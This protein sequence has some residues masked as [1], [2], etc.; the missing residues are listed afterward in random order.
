MDPDV[1]A[2]RPWPP[3]SYWAKVTIVVALTLYVLGLAQ[4]VLNIV[5]LVVIAAVLAIGLDPAVRRL[6]RLG[7]RR[8][9]AVVAIFAGFVLF[10]V[11]F[12]WVV[13]PPLVHQVTQL[14]NDI[15]TYAQRL[16]ARG[17]WV[18]RYF[19]DHD[20]A[21]TVKDFVANLP[22]RI[23]SSFGTILGVAG[24]VGSALFNVVTVAILMIYFM[25]ALPSMRKGSAV[26]FSPERRDRAE[27]VMDQS[28]A[29]IGGYVAGNLVTSLICG[30]L[31]LLAFSVLGVPFA[32]PL[33]M[34]AG[35][36]DL[37]PAV[38]SYLGAAPAVAVGFFQSPLTGVLVLSY[39]LVYQQFENYFLVPK[40]M[41]N[42]V[43]LSPAAVIISTLVG[44]SL[45]G[46]AGALLALP[47]AATIKV[48]LYDVWLRGRS[49]GDSLVQEHLQAELAAE[50]EAEAGAAARAANRRRMVARLRGAFRP[51]EGP[52][53]PE[54]PGPSEEPAEEP[55]EG[56]SE[57]EDR[58]TRD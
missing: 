54:G 13:V 41:Q 53:P 7:M 33:A 19:R 38:G 18:G 35:I 26:L 1:R 20:V 34:W 48:I 16:E 4:S 43:N 6:Q 56:P 22:Q 40:V 2:G 50:A 52:R 47:G 37:I 28:I 11:L 36:A 39:F 58:G 17:D 32:I 3:M 8:G 31:A 27:R 5:I 46:F 21:R 51:G 14:A 49:E 57:E 24:K 42:A 30:V 23:A 29:K 45:F 12:A 44:G 10:V 9:Y 55:A 15:P 25:L